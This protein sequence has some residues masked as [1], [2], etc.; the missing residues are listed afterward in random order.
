MS[1]GQQFFFII[2]SL[3]LDCVVQLLLFKSP[4]NT[5]VEALLTPDSQTTH[6]DTHFAS[7]QGWRRLSR[8]PIG[9][10]SRDCWLSA[11][12][13]RSMRIRQSKGWESTWKVLQRP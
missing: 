4:E 11:V 5:W 10:R 3:L 6:L 9:C 12:T 1:T 13:S 7:R 8:Q 2:V